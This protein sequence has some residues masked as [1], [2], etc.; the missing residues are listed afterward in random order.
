MLDLLNYGF[1]YAVSNRHRSKGPTLKAL[2]VHLAR[3][4]AA[5]GG[6]AAERLLF[7][8]RRSMDRLQYMC[9]HSCLTPGSV[10]FTR[11]CFMR[12]SAFQPTQST[13][14]IQMEGAVLN[15]TVGGLVMWLSGKVH[16]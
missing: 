6:T 4:E 10:S 16:A 2:Q 15:K 7:G 13:A 1:T 8:Y 5:A 14:E 11:F 3:V 12:L 9:P